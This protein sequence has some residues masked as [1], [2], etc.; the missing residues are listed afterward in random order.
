MADITK[1]KNT[2]SI[3]A[4]FKDGDDR[5]LTIDNPVSGLSGTDIHRFETYAPGI[6]VGDKDKA[7]FLRFKSAK[8]VSSTITTFDLNE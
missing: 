8:V 6:L 3:V 5:T 2:L 4:E 1:T 7:D